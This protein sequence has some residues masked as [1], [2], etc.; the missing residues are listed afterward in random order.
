MPKTISKPRSIRFHA[1]TKGGE[2]EAEPQPD[3]F[4]QAWSS[5]SSLLS[6]G[7]F[8]DAA[9]DDAAAARALAKLRGEERGERRKKKLVAP[10]DVEEHFVTFTCS[11]REDH[12]VHHIKICDTNSFED[13]M[14][15]IC[16]TNSFEDFMDLIHNGFGG[17]LWATHAIHN[18][19]GG[20]LWATYTNMLTGGATLVKDDESFDAICAVCEEE[21]GRL[22]LDLTVTAEEP[23]E[24]DS[25]DEL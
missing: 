24:V 16:D 25:D 19:F 5:L 11:S 20:Q 9:G 2:D 13:F 14:D 23:P 4:S 10:A 3:L 8:G 15:L 1:D 17:Q 22:K 12:M 7:N 21:G 18:E 6:F